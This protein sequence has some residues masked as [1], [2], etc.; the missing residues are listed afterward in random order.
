MKVENCLK[1]QIKIYEGKTGKKI[2]V[3]ELAKAAA[4]S[5]DYI[6]KMIRGERVGSYRVLLALSQYFNCH[7]EDLIIVRSNKTLS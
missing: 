2:S 6:R 4:V 3:S 7:I 5:E 1:H